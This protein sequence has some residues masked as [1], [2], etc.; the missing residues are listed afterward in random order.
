MCPHPGRHH[1]ARLGIRLSGRILRAAFYYDRWEYDEVFD[2]VAANLATIVEDGTCLGF[3]IGPLYEAL[4]HH[5][6]NK[7]DL[8][9]HSPHITDALMELIESGAVS[10]RHKDAFRG[11]LWSATPW[12]P[13]G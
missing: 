6:K 1:G 13:P 8:G 9:I 10:N 3:A 2:Q 7:R 12:A 5:L 4:A 11:V